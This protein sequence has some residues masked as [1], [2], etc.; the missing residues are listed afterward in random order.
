MMLDSINLFF[1]VI[2]EPAFIQ[3]T[4][5]KVKLRTQEEKKIQKTCVA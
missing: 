5:W 2:K 4:G 3:I 1:D